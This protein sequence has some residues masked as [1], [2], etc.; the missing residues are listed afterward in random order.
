MSRAFGQ[1]IDV[2]RGGSTFFF[3]GARPDGAAS[4]WNDMRLEA[5]RARTGGLY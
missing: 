4:H 2:G 5:D 1:E 3:L